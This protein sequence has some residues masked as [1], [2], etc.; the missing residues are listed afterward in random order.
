M[1]ILIYTENWDGKFKKSTCE[2]LSYAAGLAKQ[3]GDNTVALSIGEVND[4]ELKTLSNYGVKKVISVAN[5]KLKSFVNQAYASVIAEVAVKE[6]ASI[7]LFANNY[8]GRA[9]APCVS[10]KL[11]A[12]M[13][14]GVVKL[15]TSTNP[16]IIRQKAFSGKAFADVEISS[17]IKVLTL[18]QNSY[19]IIEN[20]V[21]TEYVTFEPALKDSDFGSQVK[22]VIK[23][24]G[25]ILITEAETLVSGGRGMK[26]ANNWGMLEEMADL[27]NA[28]TCCSRPIT[29]LD[30]RPHHEHVGQTGKVVAPNLYIALGISGAIQHLAGVNGSKV[31]VAVNNDSDAPIFE[32]ADYGIVGDIFDVVPKLNAAIKKYKSEA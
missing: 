5:G 18:S 9:L 31:I 14:A 32:A 24:S 16:F 3:T 26:A 23:T 29:D 8:S 4:S 6:A 25:K 2:L 13:V 21:D 15:P 30:W 17:A 10:V 7:V 22:E 1:A 12:G 11:N 20:K 27:L 19:E 28:A